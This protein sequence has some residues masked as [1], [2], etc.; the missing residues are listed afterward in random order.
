MRDVLKAWALSEA[1]RSAQRTSSSI[2]NSMSAA[3]A[4]MY[5][6]PLVSARPSFG[7][8][9]SGSQPSRPMTSDVGTISPLWCTLPKPSSGNA[10]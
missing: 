5:W 9:V 1:V 4:L 7:F 3:M 2:C 10:R 8:K 6:T